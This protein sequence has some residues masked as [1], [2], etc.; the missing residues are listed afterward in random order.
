MKKTKKVSVVICT[1]NGGKY[2]REQLDSIF[3][4]TYPLYEVYVQDDCSTDNTIEIVRQYQ[5][6]HPCLRYLINETNKG[7]NENF[8]SALHSVSGDYI[9][10][11]DQDDIWMP[12]KIEKQMEQIGDHL[13]CFC[14]SKPFSSD[15]SAIHFDKEPSQ[16]SLEHL[17][18]VSAI[19]GHTMLLN[20]KILPLIPCNHPTHYVYDASIAITASL[21]DSIVFLNEFLCHHRRFASAA[22][23]LPPRNYQKSLS[24]IIR[25]FFTSFSI[26]RSLKG[27]VKEHYAA[28]TSYIE[29]HGITTPQVED[30]KK[31]T[32]W[33][34]RQSLGAQLQI[35]RWCIKH[36]D[37]IFYKKETNPL[38]AWGRAA[39]F[40]ILLYQYWDYLMPSVEDA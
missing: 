22:T 7:I 15:G 1:Y 38:L 5:Q 29:S 9:A 25:I 35:S 23:F 33:L 19:S 6:Q 26:F 18:F 37:L 24:N 12:E 40:P 30:C 11:S 28:L 13:L 2:L 16:Y 10:I 4:Q 36:R 34:S 3:N 14:R 31:V 32:Q 39:L 20:K 8:F 27:L 17:I 21:Y